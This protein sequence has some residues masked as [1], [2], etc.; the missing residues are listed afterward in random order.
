MHLLDVNT[1]RLKKYVVEKD[2]KIGEEYGILSHRWLDGEEEVL[3]SD[4]ESADHT[5]IEKKKGYFKLLGCCEQAKCDNL[6]YVWIDTCCINRSDS[7][8]LQE[9]I[10]SMYRWYQNA[11]TCYVY[12]KDTSK[13]TSGP[14]KLDKKEDW[15]TRGWTL[16]ELIAPREVQFYDK[17][18][19]FLGD[20]A[21]LEDFIFGI[22]NIDPLILRGDTTP[23][24]YSIA[25]RMAWASGRETTRDEDLAYCL[26]GLF[27]VN[28]P[29]LYGEGGTK[30]FL[31]LQEE[32]I[33]TNDDYSIFAW[34]GIQGFHGL[35]A[36]SPSAFKDCQTVRG[37]IRRSGNSPFSMTNRGIS[38]TLKLTPWVQNTYMADIHCWE[39][40]DKDGAIYKLGIFLRRLEADDQYARVA[41]NGEDFY[42]SHPKIQKL[43]SNIVPIYVRQ[44]R[45]GEEAKRFADS[46]LVNGFQIH[47]DLLPEVLLGKGYWGLGRQVLT[48]KP[49]KNES[50]NVGEFTFLKHPRIKVARLGF[51]FEFNPTILLCERTVDPTIKFSNIPLAKDEHHINKSGW[52]GANG[53]PLEWNRIV[54]TDGKTTAMANPKQGLW[55]LKADRLDGL[56]VY[57]GSTN[58]KVTLE[59]GPKHNRV[60]TVN[61]F[62]SPQPKPLA[63]YET[64]S[65]FLS[66][67]NNIVQ[68]KMM[69][70]A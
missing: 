60:W 26:V 41:V 4:L 12:L 17:S 15:F 20:R 8:E 59:R 19:E 50:Y 51:D 3:F 66:F 52:R 9:A 2:G 11:Y 7:S 64:S 70:E 55:V 33:K 61:I 21:S 1:R 16:Q 30:A 5:H 42:H 25:I 32:I 36:L 65:K 46:D 69:K 23:E 27:D 45:G 57:L 35:L 38:I 40:P 39:R 43:H 53:V 24:D 63:G 62:P 37:F 28:M 68:E 29:M 31:R 56:E 22:T 18:W 6:K 10:N 58:T 13:P 34:K 47:K 49:G 48:F 67:C 44:F 14:L 54:T